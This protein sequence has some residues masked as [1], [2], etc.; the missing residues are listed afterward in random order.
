MRL[1]AERKGLGDMLAEGTYR[2]ALKINEMKGVNVLPYA[3]VS[4]GI[5][6]GAHGIRSE[7]DYPDYASYSCSV[8]G[9]DHTSTAHLP[10]DHDNS[11]L[12]IIL[13]DSGVFCWFNFFEKESQNLLWELFESVTGWKIGAEEWFTTKAR[14]ILHIQRA[15]LLLGGPDLRWKPNLQDE[16]PSRW[17][18]PLRAGPYSGKAVDPVRVQKTKKEYYEAVGWDENGVPKSEELN[19]LGLGD[20][21]KRLREFR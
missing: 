3:V 14:R 2:A 4:K 21:D 10:I 18:E 5:G 6:I 20:V 9:G 8:Q 7:K 15:A 12:R 16:I 11:E 1:I 17:Y 19:R 13:Y